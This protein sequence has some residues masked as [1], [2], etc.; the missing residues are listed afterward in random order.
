[1][2]VIFLVGLVSMIL[3]RTLRKDYARFGRRDD[4]DGDDDV[5]DEAGWKQVHADVFR[6][7]INLPLFAALVGTGHQLVILVLLV[8]FL[9]SIGT[10][11]SQCAPPFS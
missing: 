7:P 1:M 8:L 5:G 4:E 9:A 3:M 11:Y 6:S 10:Y 2:M